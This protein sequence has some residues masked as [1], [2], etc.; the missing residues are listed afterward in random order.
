MVFAKTKVIVP[1]VGFVLSL[2]LILVA[3]QA[4][5]VCTQKWVPVNVVC[6]RVQRGEKIAILLCVYAE[7]DPNTYNHQSWLD[8][9]LSGIVQELKVVP[10]R[11]RLDVPEDRQSLLA[12]QQLFPSLDIQGGTGFGFV[13]SHSKE[14]DWYVYVD[15]AIAF[16][17]IVRDSKVMSSFSKERTGT[18]IDGVR[19]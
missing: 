19:K 10:C 13:N 14:S 3:I 9:N 2:L 12:L 17:M 6:D 8:S 5:S 16:K 4:I 7:W 1:V 15:T 11:L 18:A